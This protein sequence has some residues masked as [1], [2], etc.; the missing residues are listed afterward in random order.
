[1]ALDP[2]RIALQLS[3]LRD[4]LKTPD[5][6]AR[7]FAR[8]RQIGYQ[9]LELAGLGPMPALEVKRLA[10]AAGLGIC[11]SHED[12]RAIV[13]TPQQVADTLSRWGCR[14]AVYPSPHVPLETL[15]Q[16]FALA[17]DL[18]RAGEVLRS[19]GQLLTYHNHA[20]EFRKLQGKAIL[21]WLYER[22]DPVLVHAELDTYW[23]QAGGA[24]PA[25]YCARLSGRL[26]LLHLKDYAVDLDNQPVTAALGEGNL[27]LP[28]ILRE[29]ESAGCEWYIV[30]Q[31]AGFM[32]P[33]D[34]VATSLRYLE[35]L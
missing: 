24:D 5:E 10:D 15:D 27:R 2:R 11:A 17:D 18:N 19:R 28:T 21:D 31:D 6:V 32:D 12:P 30:E 8:V 35:A 7:S 3:T 22:T 29:A 4:H 25:G 1:M 33:F 26:P 23:V 14:F 20:L 13:E 34:A 16:V 9:C